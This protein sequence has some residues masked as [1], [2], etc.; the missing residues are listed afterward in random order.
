MKCPYC[1]HLEN[2]VV[3][4]R[5]NKDFTITRRRRMCEACQRRFTTYERL[6]VTMPM[7]IKKDGRREAWDRHKVVDGIKKACEK[8]PVSIEQIEEF[9][10]ELEKELQDLG[11]REIPVG[12]VGERVM[13]GLR[14]LDGVAYVRFASVYRQFKDLNEF[15]HEL[16]SM[17]T[18]PPEQE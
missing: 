16:K 10:D 1:G 5:L 9:A 6:E 2:R 15:M 18:T 11:E 17:L 13:D 4:S 14:R 12:R 8:R 3:D 7:L